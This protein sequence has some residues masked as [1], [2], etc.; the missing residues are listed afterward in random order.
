MPSRVLS[1][2][3]S[4]DSVVVVVT[5][6]VVVF[7]MISDRLILRPFTGVCFLVPFGLPIGFLQAANLNGTVLDAD[8]ARYLA[9]DC[10]DSLKSD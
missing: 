1:K 3:I 5:V 4:T 7:F 6:V 2:P 8:E 10:I 9:A